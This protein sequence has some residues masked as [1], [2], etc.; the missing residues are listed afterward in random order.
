M[1]YKDKKQA[2]LEAIFADDPMDLLQVRPATTPAR[3]T[4]DRLVAAFQEIVTFW[5]KTPS[6]TIG[7]GRNSRTP[8]FVAAQKFTI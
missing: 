5:G 3:T 7:R 6:F 8:I 4:D 1:D 2:V